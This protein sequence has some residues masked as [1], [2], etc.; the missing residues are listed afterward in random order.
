MPMGSRQA[1]AERIRVRIKSKSAMIIALLS[2]LGKKRG[3]KISYGNQKLYVVVPPQR[4]STGD[5]QAAVLKN[6]M[7]IASQ[8]RPFQ[9]AHP[10]CL[11][12]RLSAD[13]LAVGSDGCRSMGE[14]SALDAVNT[15]TTGD[16]PRLIPVETRS[17][18]ET[19][20]NWRSTSDLA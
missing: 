19:P 18:P 16:R 6:R 12:G 8:A 1:R 13:L 11:P 4:P 14:D 9:N 20:V 17:R 15:I 10:T 7:N 3:Q 2:V 5:L